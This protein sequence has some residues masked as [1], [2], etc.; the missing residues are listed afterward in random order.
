LGEP[1]PPVANWLGKG[2]DM[3]DSGGAVDP[4][5]AVVGAVGVAVAGTPAGGASPADGVG[6]Q[7]RVVALQVDRTLD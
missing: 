3:G 7:F 5:C 6:A 1:P 4:G 2:S